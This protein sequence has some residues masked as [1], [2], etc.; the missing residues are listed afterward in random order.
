M[1]VFEVNGLLLIWIAL[2]TIAAVLIMSNRES[3]SA[4]WGSILS[5]FSG[6]GGLAEFLKS[7][8]LPHYQ[9]HFVMDPYSLWIGEWIIGLFLSISHY[10]SPYAFLIF[11]ISLTGVLGG[12][13]QKYQRYLKM[14][15]LI[16]P[17]AMFILYPPS[18]GFNPNQTV[19]TIWAVIYGAASNAFL[20]YT[21]VKSKSQKFKQQLILGF[22]IFG[23]PG[24]YSLFSS[25]I[26]VSLGIPDMWKYNGFFVY[27]MYFIF[28][29]SVI[30]YGVFGARMRLEKQS[31]DRNM[32]VINSGTAMM[33]H[34][35]KN[36]LLKIAMSADNT[37]LHISPSEEKINRNMD[38]I[39]ESVQHTFDMVT[40]IQEQVQSIHPI[41]EEHNLEELLK[42][43][44]DAVKIN[45]E[46]KNIR[47][48]LKNVNIS[49]QCDKVHMKE[50]FC[51][52]LNNAVEA[53]EKDGF[54]HIWGIKKGRSF[55]LTIQDNGKGIPKHKLPH[56]MEP[57]FTT[58]NRNT[59]YGLGL[60]YCYNVMQQH[61]GTLEI[62]SE[63]KQGTSVIL[64]LPLSIGK[65]DCIFNLTF[66]QGEKDR[67]IKKNKY[68][69]NQG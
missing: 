38:I 35:L 13:G 66:L 24:L 14:I 46:Q 31:M 54:I 2:W 29:V 69:H 53:I 55:E 60:A 8:V 39:L 58:K 30:R 47:L 5:F 1:E 67:T 3:E 44:V 6:F 17:L 18:P 62:E 64:R 19:L 51:N 40:R 52:I 61:G 16:L 59:N 23:I 4:R 11:H 68:F 22:I 21:Y 45:L 33:N 26:L 36:Q 9:S 41:K 63:E 27:P 42:S 37:K 34:T 43:A 48:N 57:F 12:W 20:V 49:L 10:L 25:Y 50:V 32:K 28:I 7:D 56:V 65:F 15:L